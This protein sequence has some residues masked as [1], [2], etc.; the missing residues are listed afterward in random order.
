MIKRVFLLMIKLVYSVA[1]ALGTDLVMV[2]EQAP[3]SWPSARSH[4][5][6]LVVYS[7]NCLIQATVRYYSDQV[8]GE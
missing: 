1:V 2:V 3:R 8:T 4:W 7:R 6:I 5:A